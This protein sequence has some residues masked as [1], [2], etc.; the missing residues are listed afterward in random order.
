MNNILKEAVE[1]YQCS[2]CVSGSDISCYQ[3]GNSSACGAHVAGTRI[4]NIGRIFLGMPTGFNRLGTAEET[5]ID[6]WE[7]YEEQNKNWAYDMFNVPVWKH[8]DA[9]KD[10]TLIRG[11]SP[12]INS[13]FIHIVLEDCLDKIDCI[14]ITDEVI[15]EMD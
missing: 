3:K 13:P 15:R 6:I 4:F 7:T 9:N 12:R 10:N 11:I 2:G 14:E 5:K 1:E 8:K